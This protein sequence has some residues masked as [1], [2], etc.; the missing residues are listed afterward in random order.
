MKANLKLYLVAALLLGNSSSTWSQ[1][2]TSYLDTSFDPGSG[3]GGG[4]VETVLPQPDGKVLV[5]G[6]F[7]SFNGAPQGY[8]AR[9]NSDGSIDTSFHAAPGYWV[10]HM[11]LQAD[12][13]IIIGGWFTNVQG[14]PRNRIARLNADGSLD[15]SFNPGTGAEVKIV[16][17]DPN[18]PFVFAVAVQPDGKILVGGN[19]VNYNGVPSSGLVRLNPDGSQDTSFNVGAGANSWVRSLLVLPNG[20]IMVTGWFTNFNNHPFNRMVRL[21][22]D[23]SYDTSFYADFGD[24]TAVYTVALQ[25]NGNMVIGG[26]F[27]QV[28]STPRISLAGVEPNGT[29]DPAFDPGS[30]ADGFVECARVQPDG[31]IVIGGYFNN[32]DGTVRHRVARVN[33]DGSVDSSLS[34]DIDNFVW[35]VALQSDGK[36]LICGGF[37]T[38]DGYSRVGVARLLSGGRGM[39][40]PRLLD[41]YWDHKQFVVPIQTTSGHQYVLQFKESPSATWNSLPPVA[42]DD[43]VK[44]LIDP[45][46]SSSSCRLYRVMIN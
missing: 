17:G 12:G 46:A 20:Q 10:R 19:F 1:S 29:A 32:L 39:I 36:V 34:A 45:G 42:G 4:I 25:A 16:Q 13:K 37:T 44:P 23:G 22:P 18:D 26:H 38:V 15:T 3:A 7:T 2:T 30:G 24:K 6:N 14:V 33:P 41:P 31:R 27:Y 11:A 21:N 9:L 8:I 35:T 28:N 5:C 43:T 40:V